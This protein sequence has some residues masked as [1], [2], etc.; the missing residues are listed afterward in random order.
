MRRILNSKSALQLEIM[1]QNQKQAN[2]CRSLSQS[3]GTRNGI[4]ILAVADI[5]TAAH[6]DVQGFPNQ[7]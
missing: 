4:V 6:R 7:I 3:S 5:G 2:V 1:L